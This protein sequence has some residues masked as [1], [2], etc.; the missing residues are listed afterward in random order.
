MELFICLLLLLLVL[1]LASSNIESICIYIH[2][3]GFQQ[4]DIDSYKEK[5]REKNDI[6]SGSIRNE[7]E[8]S[9]GKENV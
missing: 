6:M 7:N 3:D 2:D 5:R 4:T 9:H 8:I 1:L